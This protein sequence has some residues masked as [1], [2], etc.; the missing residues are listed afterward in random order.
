MEEVCNNNLPM[1]KYAASWIHPPLI[2]PHLS[3]K[4]KA[5]DP[6]DILHGGFVGL[7]PLSH[8]QMSAPCGL[9]PGEWMG[10]VGK[11][12]ISGLIA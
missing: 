3:R 9:Y 4:K 7:S 12:I 6:A 11:E 1:Y 10:H 5:F 2:F 8:L